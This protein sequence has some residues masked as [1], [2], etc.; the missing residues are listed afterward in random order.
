M[1]IIAKLLMEFLQA[2]YL[3]VTNDSHQH[4]GHAGKPHGD[5]THFSVVIVSP[6][7]EGESLIARHKMVYSILDS[8]LKAGLHA[9]KLKTVT[10]AEYQSLEAA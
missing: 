5:D 9:L 3:K 6:L 8:H 7:F 10:P 4:A 2:S 1:E